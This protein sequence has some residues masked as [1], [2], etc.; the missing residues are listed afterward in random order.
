V[1]AAGLNMLELRFFA[2]NADLNPGPQ[3]NRRL[4]FKE[5]P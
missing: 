5:G 2:K 3:E 1:E 4:F